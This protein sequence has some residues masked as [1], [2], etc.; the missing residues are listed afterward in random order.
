ML[1]SVLDLDQQKMLNKFKT[2]SREIQRRYPIT[3]Y[4]RQYIVNSFT[5]LDTVQPLYNLVISPHLES[6]SL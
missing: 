1:N 6:I 5:N 3:S 4:N 2:Y